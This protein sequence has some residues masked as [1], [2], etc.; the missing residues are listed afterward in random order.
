MRSKMKNLRFQNPIQLLIHGQ[1]WSM[2]STH[3]LH[4]EQWW[5]RSGL[6]MLH[7]RQYR[8]RLFSGSPK[9]NPQKTGTCP[10]S[11][12]IDWMKDQTSMKNKTWKTD[13]SRITLQSSITKK[14][15]ILVSCA[16]VS[17]FATYFP[18]LVTKPRMCMRN[19]WDRWRLLQ[20]QQRCCR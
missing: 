12:V 3:L 9:W 8:R 15:E 14:T 19:R 4:E 5:Q 2:F 1:W 6:N 16:G 11:V 7:M 17:S 18:L 13:K 20:E 10:G